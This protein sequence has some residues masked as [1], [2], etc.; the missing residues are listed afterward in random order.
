MWCFNEASTLEKFV[1]TSDSDHNEGFSKCSLEMS[2]AGRARF[3][4]YLDVRVPKDGRIKKAGYCAMRSK[5]IRVSIT[6]FC[7][8]VHQVGFIW[9]G[10]T[11][12]VMLV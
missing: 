4:G 7:Y 3:H 10:N 5:R 12:W 2:E 8:E 6:F 9:F 1:T 11:K